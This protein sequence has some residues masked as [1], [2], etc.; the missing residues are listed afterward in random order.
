MHQI[1]QEKH[2]A[3]FREASECKDMRA[4]EMVEARKP[5]KFVHYS[6]TDLLN[7]GETLTIFSIQDYFRFHA[8]EHIESA[9]KLASEKNKLEARAA[10]KAKMDARKLVQ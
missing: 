8:K 3:L 7:V 1:A 4:S 6:E 5:P 2:D 10:R 9:R